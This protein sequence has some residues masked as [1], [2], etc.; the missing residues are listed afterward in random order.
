MAN[1]ILV[2]RGTKSRIEEIKSTLDTNE[3]V[4]ATDTGEL[5]VKKANGEIEYFKNA[6]DIDVIVDNKVDKVSGKGL[7]KN[8][9]TDNYKNKLD[10]I[11]AGA[12][13]NTVDSVNGKTGTVVINKSDVGLSNVDNT[14]DLA[15]PISTATQTALNL[16]A[17]KTQLNNYVTTTTF[18]MQMLEKLGIKPNGTDLLIIDG[19]INPLY[20]DDTSYK[21]NHPIV[22]SQSAMLALDV[23]AGTVVVRTDTA[24]KELFLLTQLPASTLANWQLVSSNTVVSVAG[25]TGAIVLGITDIS[26]LN[27]ALN[28]KLD[29]TTFED[30]LT[31]LQ[32]VIDTKVDKV[33]G[34]GL[35]TNDYTT[36]EKNKLDGIEAGAEK[37]VVLSVAGKTG[38]VVLA[39]GDVGLGNV[40]N[41]SSA[42]IRSEITQAN[43]I[44]ALG[45]TP[46]TTNTTYST[47]SKTNIEGSSSSG[48][49]LITGQRFKQGLEAHIE[50]VLLG[51]PEV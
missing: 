45:Y 25:K 7:S 30:Q 40:E 35:S 1:K 15:K 31:Q 38:N 44:N 4:Y 10:N 6:T 3:L 41:K 23:P 8:D 49:G 29:I 26:G 12:E 50:A 19:M 36:A 46:P 47:I 51:L 21:V 43:V 42:T 34:K 5:G 37:N 16:K 22:N 13:K 11:E 18:D 48:A 27:S 32:D 24:T 9:F 2:A 39:K 20:I 14:A 28:L 17:D 33:S